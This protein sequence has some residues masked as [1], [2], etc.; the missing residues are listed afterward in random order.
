MNPLSDFTTPRTLICPISRHFFPVEHPA[1]VVCCV[2]GLKNGSRL[3]FI[4]HFFSSGFGGLAASALLLGASTGLVAA[5][6][7]AAIAVLLGRKVLGANASCGFPA[8]AGAATG[9]GP[10]GF[11]GDAATGLSA[12]WAGTPAASSAALVLVVCIC[13]SDFAM[14]RA[15]SMASGF[16]P[17]ASPVVIATAT[18][19]M[20]VVS[21]ISDSYF[22]PAT[23]VAGLAPGPAAG[24]SKS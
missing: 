23:G 4:A 3:P 13:C 11:A 15:L 5:T 6:F 9:F 21:F 16:C 18:A 7:A 14:L 10:A 19:R 22:T 8:L 17:K 1:V 2:I 20:P 12:C 24:G